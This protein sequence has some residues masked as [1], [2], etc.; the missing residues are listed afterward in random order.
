MEVE[1]DVS[2]ETSPRA[3]HRA[4][5]LRPQ[6]GSPDR[7]A[8]AGDSPSWPADLGPLEKGE[9]VL[10]IGRPDARRL[11]LKSD[12]LL[13]PWTVL[14]LAF[15][16]LWELELLRTTGL[17]DPQAGPLG[18]LA[19]FVAVPFILFGLYAIG[20]RL[21]IRRHVRR[22]TAY[23]VTSKRIVIGETFFGTHVR[24]VCVKDLSRVEIKFARGRR[25]GE[26]RFIPR[27]PRLALRA[28]V[29]EDLSPTDELPQLLKEKIHLAVKS[30]H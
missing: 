13:L 22:H 19:P 6:Q 1:G 21:Y 20:P 4:S 2:P 25:A 28:M 27:L 29:F 23:G 11:F 3:A 18:H 15:A 12:W 17:H 16:A 9:R 24:V 14:T 5:T 8:K 26:A 30:H 10:W 7:D